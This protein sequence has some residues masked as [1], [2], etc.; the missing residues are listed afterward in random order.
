MIRR[1]PRSTLFPYTTLFRSLHP[2]QWLRALA[3]E[4]GAALRAS[5]A[6]GTGDWRQ[7]WALLCGLALTVPPGDT[8]SETAK[9]ARARFPDIKDPWVTALAEAGKAAKLLADRGLASGLRH[10]ADGSPAAGDPL[11]A[12][13]ADGSRFLLVASCGYAQ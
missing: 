12:C 2:A 3:E 11:V 13:D 9:L 4:T 5:V 6:D 1:P 7:L 8:Q 10:L